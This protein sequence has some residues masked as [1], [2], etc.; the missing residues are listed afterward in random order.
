MVRVNGIDCDFADTTFKRFRGLMLKRNFKPL[1]FDF[2]KDS[3][4]SCSL[5]TFFMLEPI[6]IVFIN[7]KKEIVD[8]QT[9]KP[10]LPLIRPK[11]KAR[12]VLELSAGKG[13]KFRL[14]SKATIKF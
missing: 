4:N 6:D 13:K 10:W 11:K 12:Y 8:I 2:G 9:A 7:S 3:R 1:F 5:H 14:S